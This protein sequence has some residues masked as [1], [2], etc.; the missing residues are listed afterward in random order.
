MKTMPLYILLIITTFIEPISLNAQVSLL[1]ESSSSYGGK[2]SL[3]QF[4]DTRARYFYVT[5]TVTKECKIYDPNNF[6]L[7]YKLTSIDVYDVFY[8]VIPDM[9]SNGHPEV[10]IYNNKIPGSVRIRDLLTGANIYVWSGGGF[11]YSI[12]FVG[13]T[14][15]SNVLKIVLLKMEMSTY[16]T[17]LAIYS[18]GVTIPTSVYGNESSNKLQ[19]EIILHQNYPNP[20]NPLT[21]IHFSIPSGTHVMLRIFNILGEEVS[22]LLNEW[23]EPGSYTSTWNS[24][25]NT[26][27]VYFYRL[28][29]SVTSHK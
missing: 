8:Y 12:Y 11:W 10:L 24:S 4:G 19:D 14:P 2:G 28:Q 20:F 25:N 5:D 18:L 15:G 29:T 7:N 22:T 16:N 27:G 26:S 1:W 17:S 13:L 21:E 9:N 6:V 3:F 23:K